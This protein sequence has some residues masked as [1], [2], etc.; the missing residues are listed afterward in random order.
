MI[1]AMISLLLVAEIGWKDPYQP[2]F[3]YL[4]KE[5]CL[6]KWFPIHSSVPASFPQSLALVP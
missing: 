3:L 1:S 4:K 5:Y 6:P 2:L